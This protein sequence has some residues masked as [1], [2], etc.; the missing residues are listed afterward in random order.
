[1]LHSA[2][3]QQSWLFAYLCWYCLPMFYMATLLSPPNR[4]IKPSKMCKWV[5]WCNTCKKNG[6]YIDLTID[7]KIVSFGKQ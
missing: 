7:R 5:I 2:L 3:I 4:G 6:K 1:M